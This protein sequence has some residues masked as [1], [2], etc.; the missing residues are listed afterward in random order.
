VN[1]LRGEMSLVGPRPEQ[2]ELVRRYSAEQ[3]LCLIVKPGI[4]GPM[5]VY[6][7]GALGLEERVV[8]DRDYIENISLGRDVR[9]LAMTISAVVKGS[10]AF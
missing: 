1:V 10:G 4:T 8:V 7:R 2:V 6:G 5:Q 9:I 3:R